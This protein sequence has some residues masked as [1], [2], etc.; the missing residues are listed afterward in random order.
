LNILKGIPR[1]TTARDGSI[2]S[3]LAASDHNDIHMLC[4]TSRARYG[5]EREERKPESS[6]V[7]SQSQDVATLDI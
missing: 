4:L 5:I 7:V 6:E 3:D 1:S 2:S